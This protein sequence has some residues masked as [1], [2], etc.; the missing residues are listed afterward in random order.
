MVEQVVRLT[1]NMT[2][3]KDRLEAFKSIAHTMTE[4]CKAEPGTI[5][6]EWFAAA[7]GKRFRLMETYKDANSVE[8]HLLG[9]VV[10]QM[11][12]KLAEQCTVEGVELYGNPGPKGT[13]LASGLGAVIFPYWL[14]LNR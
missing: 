13:E 8:A 5:G 2:V 11:L 10:Q 7:D 1:I 9:P 14:G 6:Y 3:S 12:P 4:A